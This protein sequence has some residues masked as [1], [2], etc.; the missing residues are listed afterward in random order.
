[1]RVWTAAA[2]VVATL[3]F[4]AALNNDVYVATSPPGLPWHVLARKAYSVVAFALV[5]YLFG[6][7]RR[8]FGRET[9]LALCTGAVALYSTGIEIGQYLVGVREGLPSNLFDVACG[10]AGGLLGGLAL[11]LRVGDIRRD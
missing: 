5:G 6:R 1:M 9:S 7:S 11:R 3:L 8:E 2:L 10:A 4:V